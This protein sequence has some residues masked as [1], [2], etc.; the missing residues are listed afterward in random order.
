MRWR[1]ELVEHRPEPERLHSGAGDLEVGEDAAPAA[2]VLAILVG[3]VAGVAEYQHRA[4]EL[5]L[6]HHGELRSGLVAAAVGSD[7]VVPRRVLGE[8]AQDGLVANRPEAHPSASSPR[9]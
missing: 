1:G 7:G 4:V 9:R 8:M 3:D 5:P 6:G 2:V